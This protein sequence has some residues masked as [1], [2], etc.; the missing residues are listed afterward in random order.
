MEAVPTPLERGK[1]DGI[2]F[3]T[4]SQLSHIYPVTVSEVTEILSKRRLQLY[5]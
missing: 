5:Y 2:V 1:N 3:T 4:K